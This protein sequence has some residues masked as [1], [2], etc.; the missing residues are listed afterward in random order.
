MDGNVACP[1]RWRNVMARATARRVH[2]TIKLDKN[3]L[4]ADLLNV[5]LLSAVLL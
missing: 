2:A 3:G 1:L 5:S 4:L